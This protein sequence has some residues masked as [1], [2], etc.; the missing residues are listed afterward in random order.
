MKPTSNRTEAMDLESAARLLNRWQLN[1]W[2]MDRRVT[3]K[4][5]REQAG[6]IR[7]LTERLCHRDIT[8]DELDHVLNSMN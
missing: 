5:K 1:E 6:I 3:K 2:S 8:T 7:E 4:A